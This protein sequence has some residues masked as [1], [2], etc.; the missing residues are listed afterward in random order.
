MGPQPLASLSGVCLAMKRCSFDVLAGW[1]AW[2]RML[3][4]LYHFG[5]LVPAAAV[6]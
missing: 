4:E 6:S 5:V 2:V 1:V 3:I